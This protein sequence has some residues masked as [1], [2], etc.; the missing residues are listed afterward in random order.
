VV[1]KHINH[2]AFITSDM[3]KTIRFYRDLLGMELEMG[4]GHGGFRHYFFRTGPN[5]IAFFEYA[6]AEPMKKKFH[7]SPTKEPLGYD[8]VSIDVDHPEDLFYL[9]EKLEAAG[10]EAVGPIDHGFQWSLYFFDPQNIPLEA[11]WNTVETLTKEPAIDDDMPMAIAEEGRSPQPGHWPDV[12]RRDTYVM[13]VKPGNGY[14]F[15]QHML[16]AGKVAL[17]SEFPQHVE[18]VKTL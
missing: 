18:Y 16:D 3:G 8:H 7:G 11:A 6:G 13:K 15:R 10:I 1:L 2:L 9:K 4:I 12:P 17:K 14:E 5:H